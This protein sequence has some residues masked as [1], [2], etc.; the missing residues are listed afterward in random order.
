MTPE[1][2]TAINYGEREALRTTPRPRLAPVTPV[3]VEP[4][5]DTYARSAGGGVWPNA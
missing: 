3:A 2:R 4:V 1:Q 5:G